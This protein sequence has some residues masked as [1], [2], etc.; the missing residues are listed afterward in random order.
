MIDIKKELLQWFT[1]SFDKRSPGTF[2]HTGT[3]VDFKNQQLA[4][5]LENY[6]KI[7]LSIYKIYYPL[8]TTFGGDIYVVIN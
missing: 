1:N 8:R 7:Y 2:T 5:L 6:Y 4:G 3:E